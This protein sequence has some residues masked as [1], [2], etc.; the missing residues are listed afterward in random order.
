M[1]VGLG[2]GFF[3]IPAFLAGRLLLIAFLSWG[4]LAS[5]KRYAS[6]WLLSARLKAFFRRHAV[7]APGP[8]HD[9]AVLQP[10][11]SPARAPRAALAAC[12]PMIVATAQHDVLHDEGEAFAALLRAAGARAE[13]VE[14]AG[15]WHGFAQ[16]LHVPP[17]REAVEALAARA[18]ALD[19]E[20][21][22]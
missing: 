22:G 13:H 14:C 15:L 11:R 18:A 10:L 17:A 12:P 3:T 20:L 8:L 2:R 5:H 21:R 9:A 1:S 4:L 7:G 16:S 6:G 19:A